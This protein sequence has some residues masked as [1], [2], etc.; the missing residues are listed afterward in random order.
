MLMILMDESKM[1]FTLTDEGITMHKKN[2]IIVVAVLF[3][4]VSSF[5]LFA[6]IPDVLK[7]SFDYPA[8]DLVDQGG[9][10]NGW[11]GPWENLASGIVTVL[12][13]TLG[14]EG[15]PQPGGYLEVSEAGTIYRYLEETWPDESSSTY[16]ISLIY[17]RFDGHDVDDSYNGLS[18][19]LNTS[20][21]L[22]IGKPW[23]SK[24]IGVDATGVSGG[25]PSNID[26]YGLNWIVVKLMMN[27]TAENDK[28]Y[29]WVNPDP[30]V[31]PDTTMADT[32]GTW[33]GSGGFNRLRIGSG[34]TPSPAECLYDEICFSKT[35]AGLT[36]ETDVA[37]RM[38]TPTQ[39][40]LK[41]NYP[42]PF[43][44]TT[45]ISYTV[46]R[47]RDIDIKV[48]DVLGHTVRTLFSG[49]QR[50]GAH[51]IRWDGRDDAGKLVSS[52]VYLY[53]LEAENMVHTNKMTFL[54]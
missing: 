20:E 4:L 53:R 44:P 51:E 54:R 52:G 3:L 46:D 35:Y 25:L 26:A 11:L 16:W 15:V 22:Y 5:T 50:A 43:N 2:S 39:F 42:N 21:L 40:A 36:V 31:E 32:S 30:T 12:S 6:E 49:Q 29:Y 23:A 27:G 45:T 17:Q 10:G 34:N 1:H 14:Y 24:N 48:Y 33:N 19:F 37:E 7:E 38:I 8:G 13:G 9:S 18:L 47:M 28:I 41:G